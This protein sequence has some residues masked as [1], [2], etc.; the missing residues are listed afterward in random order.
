[1]RLDPDLIKK[2]S[3]QSDLD[4]AY[5]HDTHAY[6]TN[7]FLDRYFGEA[8]APV[9]IH[10]IKGLPVMTCFTNAEDARRAG[11]EIGDVITKVDGVDADQRIAEG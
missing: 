4:P 9:R 8:S 11:L 2:K 10:L 3:L 5:I 7:P 1:M 6:I